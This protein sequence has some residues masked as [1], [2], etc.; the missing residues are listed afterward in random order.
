MPHQP[1]NE[2]SMHASLPDRFIAQAGCRFK[3]LND[4]SLAMP[5]ACHGCASSC[6]LRPVIRRRFA[7]GRRNFQR[8]YCDAVDDW[9]LY[10]NAG[11]TPVLLSWGERT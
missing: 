5:M 9:S 3:L 8:H 4:S 1:F 10:D 6:S 2:G 11:T 7:A